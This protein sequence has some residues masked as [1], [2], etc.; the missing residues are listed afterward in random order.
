M[1]STIVDINPNVQ[2]VL[3]FQQDLKKCCSKYQQTYENLAKDKFENKLSKKININNENEVKLPNI[4]SD[5]DN[6]L[7]QLKRKG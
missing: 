4:L 1:E 3:K 5:E 2:R 6:E 7:C